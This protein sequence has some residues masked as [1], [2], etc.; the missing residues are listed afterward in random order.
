MRQIHILIITKKI[1]AYVRMHIRLVVLLD[2]TPKLRCLLIAPIMAG[3]RNTL[4]ASFLF[5]EHFFRHA[6]CAEVCI[7]SVCRALA[8]GS[9]DSHHGT[10]LENVS[11][12]T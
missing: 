7:A 10:N 5:P 3:P 8:M 4:I 11:R 2:A 1:I 9:Q 12:F 6:F